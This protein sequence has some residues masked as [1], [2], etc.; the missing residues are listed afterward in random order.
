MDHEARCAEIAEALLRVVD[1]QGLEGVSLRSVAAEAGV[2][3]GRVQ[4]YFATKDQ[5]MTHALIYVH[6]RIYRRVA[7]CLDPRSPRALVRSA[8]IEMLPLD[9]ER[10]S[11]ARIAFAFLARSGVDPV[12]A[13]TLREGYPYHMVFFAQQIRLAQAAGEAHPGLDPEQEAVL[14]FALTQGLV[15]PTLIGFHT[16]ETVTQAVDLH[17]DRIFTAVGPEASTG[18]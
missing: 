16:E 9:D 8:I 1:R 15:N 3:M 11:E 5:M 6:R 14:L 17:L 4:H 10:R 12:F 2:S 18:G 13:A 7:A